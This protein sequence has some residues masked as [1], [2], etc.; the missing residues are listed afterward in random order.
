MES[1]VGKTT[2]MLTAMDNK[3]IDSYHKGVDLSK[4]CRANLKLL[5]DVE[6]RLDTQASSEFAV[7]SPVSHEGPLH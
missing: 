5:K 1:L 6:V 4:M 3:L 7:E 2:R